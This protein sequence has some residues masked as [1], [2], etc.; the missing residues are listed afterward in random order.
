MAGSSKAGR[1]RLYLLNTTA[2]GR[3]RGARIVATSGNATQKGSAM[4]HGKGESV[5]SVTARRRL[6][7]RVGPGPF[8]K[9]ELSGKRGIKGRHAKWGI[10]KPAEMEISALR[11]TSNGLE[12]ESGCKNGLCCVDCQLSC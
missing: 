7:G 3:L 1:L 5:R 8:A 12:M 11:R 2:L 9:G 6:P 4:S 10:D